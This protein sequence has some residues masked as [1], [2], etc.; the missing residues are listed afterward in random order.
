MDQN[1]HRNESTSGSVV[2][3]TFKNAIKT[4]IEESKNSVKP[5]LEFIDKMD[6]K[7]SINKV[8][9]VVE[10]LMDCPLGNH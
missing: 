1:Q 5:K 6:K 2:I 4:L 3:K 9:N 7:Q 8:R 10:R